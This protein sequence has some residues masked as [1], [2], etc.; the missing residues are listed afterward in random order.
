MV[1][2]DNVYTYTYTNIYVRVHLQDIKNPYIHN[3]TYIQLYMYVYRTG[4][5]KHEQ[6]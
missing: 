5:T 3:Y 1:K 6:Y 2:E 4:F